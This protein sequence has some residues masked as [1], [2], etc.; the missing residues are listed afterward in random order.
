MNS[1]KYA[2]FHSGCIND[3]RNIACEGFVFSCVH[4]P[5]SSSLFL[6]YCNFGRDLMRKCGH[7]PRFR[8]NFPQDTIFIRSSMLLIDTLHYLDETQIRALKD[9]FN[10]KIFPLMQVGVESIQISENN[11][12]KTRKVQEK[13]LIR[14]GAIRAIMIGILEVNY[15]RLTPFTYFKKNLSMYNEGFVLLATILIEFFHCDRSLVRLSFSSKCGYGLVAHED[16]S[17][18]PDKYQTVVFG[19]SLKSKNA[20]TS[21]SII[22]IKRNGKTREIFKEYGLFGLPYYVNSA[23]IEENVNC[24][25][26]TEPDVLV[27]IYN[28]ESGRSNEDANALRFVDVVYVCL[29]KNILAQ[30]EIL[31]TYFDYTKKID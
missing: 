9:E 26:F 18:D 3:D 8:I 28:E 12:R 2:L 4:I 6:R 23:D 20:V 7:I 29:I 24:S 13:R 19:L 25:I 10:S 31:W 30:E 15:R 14:T 21:N 16:L 11:K 5:E 1:S 17:V 27:S 22:E